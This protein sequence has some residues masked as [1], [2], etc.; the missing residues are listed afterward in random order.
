[1][2][3][4]ILFLLLFSLIFGLECEGESEPQ[5]LEQPLKSETIPNQFIVSFKKYA[6]QSELK[7]Q[8]E[9]IIDPNTWRLIPRHNTATQY[10]TDFLLIELLLTDTA[11][12][13]SL[14]RQI[15]F[16]EKIK[17]LVPQ[18]KHLKRFQLFDES[19]KE[20]GREKNVLSEKD[21]LLLLKKM[22]NSTLG[23]GARIAKLSIID[24]VPLGQRQ[25]LA[26]RQL[27]ELLGLSQLW[28]RGLSGT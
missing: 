16:N 28:E 20:P 12:Q 24:D 23:D 11:T 9:A 15:R 10:P 19:A 27:A 2:T 21:F 4:S 5:N 1:M 7:S 8:L 25:L 14:L 18:R 26:Q 22:N 6:Y 13:I 3:N 17:S